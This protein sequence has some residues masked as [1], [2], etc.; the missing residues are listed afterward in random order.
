MDEKALGHEILAIGGCF[1]DHILEVDETFLNSI[2]GAKG[3]MVAVPYEELIRILHLAETQSERR[4]GG[5][6]ANTL[7]GLRQLGHDCAMTGMIGSDEHGAYFLEAFEEMGIRGLLVPSQTPTAQVAC[8]VTPDGQ[9]T[10]RTYL[11]TACEMGAQ[12]LLPHAFHGT[13]LVHIEGYTLA[14]GELC[15]K[16]M[17]LA[18]ASGAFVSFSLAS[19]EIVEHFK[20]TIHFLLDNHVDIVFANEDEGHALHGLSPRQACE[21]LGK[22][23]SIAVVSVG[24]EGCWVSHNGMTVHCPALKVPAVD[25]IGAGDLFASGF[26]HGWM[27]EYNPEICG[28]IGCLTGGAIV[29]VRGAVLPQ[30][31]LPGLRQDIAALKTGS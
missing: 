13:R 6:A 4:P 22:V 14:N 1:V 28:L 9:R 3:G 2:S 7:R 18:T 29:Q 23:C 19:F 24:A 11:G 16:A 20:E 5:S 30:S 10:M 15:H 21:E 31:T 26:L 27:E 8:L 12:D 17:E 25:T